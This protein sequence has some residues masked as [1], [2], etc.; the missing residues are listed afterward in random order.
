MAFAAADMRF[1]NLGVGFLAVCR[2]LNAALKQGGYGPVDSRLQLQ[3]LARIRTQDPWHRAGGAQVAR[4]ISA[5][6][7]DQPA[8]F[9][10]SAAVIISIE[11][12]AIRTGGG[13]HGFGAGPVFGPGIESRAWE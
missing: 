10:V 9:D 6:G 1:G 2:N 7:L 4:P 8:F 5:L 11:M 3:M 12:D 13:L